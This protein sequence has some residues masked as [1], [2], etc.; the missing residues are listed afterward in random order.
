MYCTNQSLF[1]K[2]QLAKRNSLGY[3]EKIKKTYL[4]S[5]LHDCC[6]NNSYLSL[7]CYPPEFDELLGHKCDI[8]HGPHGTNRAPRRLVAHTGHNS[9]S[10]TG[11]IGST[12]RSSTCGT[13]ATERALG[14]LAGRSAGRAAGRA[15][16]TASATSTGTAKA[17]ALG[18]PRGL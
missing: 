15:A 8:Q 16:G 1:L 2:S 11:G 17:R 9:K 10:S 12:G 14:R 4:Q 6:R 3:K 7:F 18:L 13:G 5:L